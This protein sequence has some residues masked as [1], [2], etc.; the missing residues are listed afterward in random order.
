[1]RTGPGRAGRYRSSWQRN[2]W[3]ILQQFGLPAPL[4]HAHTHRHIVL[5]LR[6]LSVCQET[7][8]TS[9]KQGLT[10]RPFKSLAQ[11]MRKY[12]CEL[13]AV[14][15]LPVEGLRKA[16]MLWKCCWFALHVRW[17]FRLCK[18]HPWAHWRSCGWARHCKRQKHAAGPARG[19][20]QIHGAQ[21][22][23]QSGA[24]RWMVWNVWQIW[25]SYWDSEARRTSTQ[26]ATE[27]GRKWIYCGWD[28]QAIKRGV[29]AVPAT[30]HPAAESKSAERV[31]SKEPGFK[32]SGGSE[33][34]TSREP[35]W[36]CSK[37]CI[38]LWTFWG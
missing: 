7:S 3:A 24:K 9:R 19:R 1:M 11:M 32:G 37:P 33:V 38:Q 16:L 30:I 25:Q 4:Q 8:A 13:S 36:K 26:Q 15:N 29:G 20:R 27:D 34:G 18:Q 6:V 21:G 14:C 23:L 28:K 31:E 5:Q 17:S 35:C 22:C 12:P 10:L 2:Q